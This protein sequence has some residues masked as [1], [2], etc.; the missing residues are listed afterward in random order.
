M[1]KRVPSRRSGASRFRPTLAGWLFVGASLVLGLVA[2]KSQISLMF[3]IFGVMMGALHVS[4]FLS[5]FMIT[6][7]TVKRD[8]PDRAWQNQPVYLGYYLRNIRK[9]VGALAMNVEEIA[10]KGIES[11][12]GYCVHIPPRTVFRAGARFLAKRRGRISMQGIRLQTTFPF[13]LIA[14]TRR[15]DL[16]ASMVIWPARG[17]LK[18]QLLHRGAVETSSAAPSLATGGQ[19]EFFGLREYRPDDNPR[20][21]HWRRSAT[22]PTPVVREM[23]RPM[24]EI[25]WVILD[26]YCKDLSDVAHGGREKLLRFTATLTDYAF[27]RGYQVGLALAGDDRIDVYNPQAGRGQLCKLLD[28]LAEVDVNTTHKIDETVAH[29]RSDRLRHSQA[30]I[31]TEDRNRLH[32]ASIATLRA[33]CRDLTVIDRDLLPAVFED[34]PPV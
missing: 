11:V 14:T 18:R 23:S 5:H 25:L 4:A 28:A 31:I 24:P 26:T 34:A 9:R 29:I 20:W 16:G 22:K 3:V 15:I 2:V 30:I 32:K 19:D 12:A 13:G 33:R 10:P 6:R 8:M 17:R 27:A 21:I 7:L 1:A